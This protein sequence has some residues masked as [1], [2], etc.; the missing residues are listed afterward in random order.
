MTHTWRQR[1]DRRRHGP[2]CWRSST[3]RS[4]RRI[5]TSACRTHLS[6]C[7]PRRAAHRR[8]CR[9]GGRRHG[10]GGGGA[11][12]RAR[13]RSTASPASP[14]RRT[15][16]PRLSPATR[17]SAIGIVSARH[18]TPTTAS[19]EAA[20]QTLAL[21]RAGDGER[22][23]AGAALRRRLLAVGCARP[24]ASTSPAKTALTRG[25][26]KCGADIHEMNTV[27]RHVSRIKGGRLRKATPAPHADARHLR[28]AGR[29]PGHHRLGPHRSRC[30]HAGRRARRARPAAARACEA[31][32]PDVP[33]AS[34]AALADP[35]NETPKPDDPAF[36]S[37]EY[38]IIAT[39]AARA[40]RRSRSWPG[41]GLRGR[42]PRRQRDGRGAR[43]GAGACQ[44]GARG[45]GRGPQGRHPQRRRAGGHRAQRQGPRRAQPGVRAGAG[46]RAG[47][48]PRHRRRWRP[49]PTASTAAKAR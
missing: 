3:R 24:P 39:P 36:A 37:A 45:Q 17:P 10:R 46:H 11:L 48:R 35:A 22:S 21:V 27:R 19:V 32:G 28:C 30:H 40:R 12:S 16:P 20:E 18:P 41:A 6:V 25:L 14:P 2:G 47:G 7:P 5:P 44:A 43:G 33:P 8:R 15:A 38:R 1:T 29:R 31:L 13:H 23:R 34:C 49:T 26:L 42:R 9:Q 4:R